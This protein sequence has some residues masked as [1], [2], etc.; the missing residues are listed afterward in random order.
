MSATDVGR[1]RREKGQKKNKKICATN[2]VTSLFRKYARYKFSDRRLVGAGSLLRAGG[3][4]HGGS[5]QDPAGGGHHGRPTLLHIPLLIILSFSLL[6]L[7]QEVN[8]WSTHPTQHH[9]S[10]PFTTLTAYSA[11][12]G[13]YYGRPTL[14]QITLLRLL[15]LSLLTLLQEVNIMVNPP[16]STS[17]FSAFYRSHGY[18]EKNEHG[19]G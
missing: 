8:I 9:S 19:K 2:S 12:R 7:L 14:L 11:S 16:Y 18:N 15:P 1:E 13:E 5:D 3:P 17:L 6:A 10:L 4:A